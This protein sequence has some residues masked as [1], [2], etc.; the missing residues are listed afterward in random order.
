[1][2]H[3]ILYETQA[4]FRIPLR[5]T[6]YVS[7]WI[8]HEITDTVGLF[9][10]HAEKGRNCIHQNSKIGSRTHFEAPSL[11]KPTVS[12]RGLTCSACSVLSIVNMLLLLLTLLCRRLIHPTYTSPSSRI[13]CSLVRGAWSAPFT[14]SEGQTFCLGHMSH[15]T[16]SKQKTSA[17]ARAEATAYASVCA[18]QMKGD[19]P[20]QSIFC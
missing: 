4:V 10:W 9:V 5:N 13:L 18:V 19:G 2:Y 7:L 12:L 8:V 14:R 15:P 17:Q 1:M 11:N 3:R 16:F 6:V 20:V